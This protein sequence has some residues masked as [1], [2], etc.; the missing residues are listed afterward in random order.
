[1]IAPY[2]SQTGPMTQVELVLT[3]AASNTCAATCPS[4]PSDSLFGYHSTAEVDYP[5]AVSAQHR[6]LSSLPWFLR[7]SHASVGC[8]HQPNHA[9]ATSATRARPHSCAPCHSQSHRYHCALHGA[10]ARYPAMEP[11]RPRAHTLR[12]HRAEAATHSVLCPLATAPM[13]AVA[14]HCVTLNS[15]HP[16]TLHQHAPAQRRCHAAACPQQCLD[17]LCWSQQ[18][19]Q[20][21]RCMRRRVAPGGRVPVDCGGWLW[22][23]G[24]WRM[25]RAVCVWAVVGVV[26]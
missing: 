15:L 1:M 4:N 14:P 25:W 12:C 26:S 22:G 21:R 24:R 3:N 19:T 11:G 10:C 6:A 17:L 9:A 7:G 18:P 13:Y 5:S 20:R 16:H 8:P 23:V 2:T